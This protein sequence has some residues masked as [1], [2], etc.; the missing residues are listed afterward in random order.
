MPLVDAE[1]LPP[2]YEEEYARLARDGR[3]VIALAHRSLGSSRQEGSRRVTPKE[4]EG[5]ST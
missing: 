2:W 4:F 3:R 1:T 5:D